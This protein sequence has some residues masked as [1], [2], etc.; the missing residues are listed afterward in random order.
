MA[1]WSHMSGSATSSITST[2][3]W[4]GSVATVMEVAGGGGVA[5][6]GTSH[7]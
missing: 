1:F 6:F 5:L 2:E 7:K 3:E 4:R